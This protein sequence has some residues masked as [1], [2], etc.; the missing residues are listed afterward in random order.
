VFWEFY[1]YGFWIVFFYTLCRIVLSIV[2][3]YFYSQ[4]TKNMKKIG[5]SYNF[6]LNRYCK[7]ENISW[8]KASG[9][10]F[11]DLILY[12]CLSWIYIYYKTV[13]FWRYLKAS[14]PESSDIIRQILFKI[15]N[16]DLSYDE[17]ISF[18]R[19][20]PRLI[21]K[22][23]YI[24]PGE[25]DFSDNFSA[26]RLNNGCSVEIDTKRRRLFF[27][28]S[29]EGVSVSTVKEYRFDGSKL[30][31]RDLEHVSSYYGDKE[32]L[33]IDNVVLESE[34][35]RLHTEDQFRA[36]SAQ[37]EIKKLQNMVEW[38]EMK[39]LG[40]MFFVMS[41][42]TELFSKTEFR[43]IVRQNLE[44]IKSGVFLFREE[45][46]RLGLN[47]RQVN[48]G[49]MGKW[50]DKSENNEYDLAVSALIECAYASLGNFGI[51]VDELLKHQQIEAQLASILDEK[52]A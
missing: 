18:F 5:L 46:K 44:R 3:P 41:H 26:Y 20:D 50:P 31:T 13:K 23:P 17:I 8:W 24:L 51:T 19:S 52:A 38:S 1:L 47:T 32:T 21:F 14:H 35:R 22:V 11:A 36:S 2:H 29:D 4:R 15:D 39:N 6:M 43:R 30:I 49:V 33:I 37:D 9:W 25:L 7:R 34:V 48:D 42:H 16:E 45:C 28:Y 10:S 12:S 27:Y 40:I